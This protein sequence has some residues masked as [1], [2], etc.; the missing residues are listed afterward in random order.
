[1]LDWLRLLL[2]TLRVLLRDRDAL[3]VESLLLRQQLAV[4]LRARPRLPVDVRSL[5]ARMSR[6][7]PLWGTER[8]RGE[9]GKVGIAVSA[10]AV[11]R[12]HWRPAPRPPTRARP[13]SGHR[14][15]GGEEEGHGLA[16]HGRAMAKAR[17][18]VTNG[19]LA[20]RCRRPAAAAPRRRGPRTDPT[21]AVL[22]RIDTGA[23]Y[24][25]R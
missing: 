19:T 11:R 25:P 12:Y 13:P 9:L 16:H 23:R 1:V 5:I 22:H 21:T 24:R 18:L 14:A 3:L 20:H 8:I 7:N 17:E 15:S 2:G 6:D 10:G 4:A